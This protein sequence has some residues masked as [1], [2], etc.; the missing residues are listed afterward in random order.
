MAIPKL[1]QASWEKKRRVSRHLSLSDWDGAP[2]E[3]EQAASVSPPVPAVPEMNLG[4]IHNAIQRENIM[5]DEDAVVSIQVPV[6]LTKYTPKPKT[7]NQG[8][9]NSDDQEGTTPPTVSSSS[10]NNNS[11]KPP[12]K[13][14]TIS[15]IMSFGHHR[16]D[17]RWDDT[18]SET[19]APSRSSPSRTSYSSSTGTNIWTKLM[20]GGGSGMWDGL[21][22]KAGDAFDDSDS[23]HFD[24]LEHPSCSNNFKRWG[25][26]CLYETRHFC[27]TLYAHPHILLVSLM[28]FGL[29][30]GVGIFAI[31]GE[32]DNY[33]KKQQM[34]ADFIARE[35]GEWFANEFRKA[36]LPLYSVQQGVVHSGYFNEAAEKIGPYPNLVIP[37]SID[38]PKIMR[39]ITGICD[40]P[41]LQEKWREIV[42]PVN[43]DNDLNGAVFG[44]RL[45]PKNVF[46]L[47]ERDDPT[48]ID[49]NLGLDAGS[50]V[51]NEFYKAIT[52]DMF[53]H[54]KFSIF[55]PFGQP[56]KEW[57]CGHIPVWTK[58]SDL[59]SNTLNVHGT[60]V[61]N[62]WGFVMNYLDWR[63]LK[64]RSNIYERFAGCNLDFELTHVPDQLSPKVVL[65]N[66]LA[67]SPQSH[68]LDETNSVIIQTNSLHGVWENRVGNICGWSPP[69]YPGAVAGVVLASLIL[70][71]LVATAL[72]E[73]TLHRNLVRKMLPRRAI[74]KLH[75][76]QTVLDCF[77]IVTVFFSDIVGFTSMAGS[78]R[79]VQVMKMLNELYTEL[80]A[81]V[82][83][84]NVYKVETI[85]DAYMVVGGAPERVPAPLAAERVALFALDAVNFVKNFRTKDGDQIFIRA[86]I[87]SGPAVGGVVGQAMPRYCF[88]GDTINFASRMESNS[89]KM[90]IQVAEV[91][92]RLLRD[93]PTMA[94]TLNKRVEGDIAG[95]HIKGKG[96]QITFWLDKAFT[97]DK[98]T[99]KNT[100]RID[101]VPHLLDLSDY[102]SDDVEA[103]GSD[104][105]FVPE[106]PKVNEA[107]VDD[108]AQDI[109]MYAP[110][111]I[112]SAMVGQDWDKLGH[113]TASSLV[114]ATDDRQQMIMR[115]SALLEHHLLRVLKERDAGAKMSLIVK[116]QIA[117]FVAEVAQTYIDVKFHNLSH[118]MH[119]TTS[120]N[121]LLSVMHN[122]D[123][124]NSFSLIFSAL[125][126]DAGHT[127]MS[128]KILVETKHPLSEKYENG[129]PI[130]EKLSLEIAL[131]IL[132]K[133]EYQAFR[134]AII[135]KVIDKIQY[136]KTLFQSILVTDIATPGRVKLGIERYEVAQNEQGEYDTR[137]C[138]LAVHIQGVFDGVGLEETVLTEYPDEFV[139]THTGLQKCVRNEHMML[140]SDISHLLQGWEHFVKWNFRL[141]K[142]LNECFA[143]GFCND[144]RDGWFE[145]QIGFLDFYIL[146]LAKRS[147]IYFDKEFADALVENGLNNRKLWTRFGVKGT[148]I[149]V[150]AAD[151]QEEECEQE[152]LRKLYELPSL[153]E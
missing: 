35:T 123:P 59:N 144:P 135:P 4:F 81:L 41:M 137:L 141:F 128:N 95:I 62:A 2:T 12:N 138:P 100:R 61:P 9:N 98:N 78:M 110:E 139:I 116:E 127:G 71:F 94:F 90:K 146:P 149:M 28:T 72:V 145:G 91:T 83:K 113:H 77:G 19:C 150:N 64:D 104:S 105:P 54:R 120:M 46:C 3:P 136:A 151:D 107:A 38:T 42:Q 24:E 31:N 106:L 66:V 21:N 103:V 36:M 65:G 56:D 132:F 17:H 39:N 33:V 148:A 101:I 73:R 97:R 45:A 34:T 79:P 25:M 29:L 131:E 55:G 134:T 99:D 119:V 153:E 82:E 58:P 50:S 115:L 84:H 87:A 51:K 125:V 15:K 133:T 93:A 57:V 22:S 43:D 92:Y 68:L 114:A 142:E 70:G 108:D 53:I 37:E 49:K 52:T 147:K 30:C 6:L 130:A 88:F 96:H 118:A 14:A 16:V 48:S 8:Q 111:E 63:L 44:Y 1:R 102:D 69:W 122:E 121:K 89:K 47:Y 140:L 11:N 27:R 76:G 7:K 20:G 152:T 112:Y 86:G 26:A 85:G 117:K 126:H 67:N 23:D 10:S 5:D 60:E 32:R 13:P 143:Q 124:L 18:Q 75:R 129:V 109:A 80:D 74:A 40:D